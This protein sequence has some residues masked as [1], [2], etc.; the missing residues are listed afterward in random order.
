MADLSDPSVKQLSHDA[1]WTAPVLPRLGG[2]YCLSAIMIQAIF[3]CI[4]KAMQ[5]ATKKSAHRLQGHSFQCHQCVF[6]FFFWHNSVKSDKCILKP[7]TNFT[8]FTSEK[9][10]SV[11]TRSI[12]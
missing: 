5:L 3:I 8:V 12:K 11:E 1:L 7:P 10:F 9:A 2:P 6:F 4:Q